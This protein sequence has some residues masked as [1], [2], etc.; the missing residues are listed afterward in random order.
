MIQKFRRDLNC[1]WQFKGGYMSVEE[2]YGG[3]GFCSLQLKIWGTPPPLDV[4]D[5][6]PYLHTRLLNF[7][8]SCLLTWF[9]A[10]F[11]YILGDFLLNCLLGRWLISLIAYLNLLVCFIACLLTYFLSSL[12]PSLPFYMFIFLFAYLLTCLLAYLLAWLLACLLVLGCLLK[13]KFA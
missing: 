9:V 1:C 8:L 13:W 4:F 2:F 5:T 11:I 10:C 7:L 12:L 3:S 6:F